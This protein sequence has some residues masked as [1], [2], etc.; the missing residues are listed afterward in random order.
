MERG[1]RDAA[2]KHFQSILDKRDKTDAYALLALGNMC[3]D[4]AV[5]KYG[6]YMVG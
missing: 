5:E 2:R 3:F 4:S 6:P 1:D